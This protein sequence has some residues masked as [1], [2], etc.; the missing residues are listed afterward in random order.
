[1]NNEKYTNS[2]KLFCDAIKLFSEQPDAL[3]NLESYLSYHFG[4]WLEK[5]AN[6]PESMAA[7]LY[8]FANI[9]NE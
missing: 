6:T 5:Y 3:E 7:E 2:A 1:M 9:Y 4:A 8:N